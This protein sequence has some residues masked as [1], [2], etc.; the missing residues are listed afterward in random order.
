MNGETILPYLI[1]VP[2]FGAFSMPIVSLAGK[3]AREA[4]AVIISGITLLVGSAVFY[5]VYENGP[6][7][8]TLGAKSPFGQE[9]ASRSG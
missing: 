1:I 4:W 6:I 5:S 7:L 2:L 9:P 8:Y 3:K